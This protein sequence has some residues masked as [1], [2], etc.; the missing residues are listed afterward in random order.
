MLSLACATPERWLQQVDESLEDILIDHAHCEKKA[1]STAMSLI[2]AYIDDENLCRAM[3]EIVNEELEQL[4]IAL[5]TAFP[6]SLVAG[7]GAVQDDEQLQFLERGF[8]QG[9]GV[10]SD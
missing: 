6:N 4:R 8:G 1:A 2:S 9:V 10:R 7:G 5:E 3:T